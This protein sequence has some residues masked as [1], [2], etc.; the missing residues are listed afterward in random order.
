MIYKNLYF[1]N[2]SSFVQ[3]FLN[4]T[5]LYKQKSLSFIEFIIK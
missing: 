3:D 1:F 5:Y 4:T 2:Y